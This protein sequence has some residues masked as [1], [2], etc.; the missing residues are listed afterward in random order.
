MGA[1][2]RAHDGSPEPGRRGSVPTGG[3]VTG[4]GPCGGSA[5]A[6]SHGSR[7]VVHREGRRSE[8]GRPQGLRPVQPPPSLV[9]AFSFRRCPPPGLPLLR[10]ALGA[11]GPGAR[12]PRSRHAYVPQSV[13]HRESGTIPPGEGVAARGT[14]LSGPE[15][16]RS[17]RHGRGRGTSGAGLLP[18]RGYPRGAG[19]PPGGRMGCRGRRKVGGRGDPGAPGGHDLPGG[20]PAHGAGRD[21]QGQ[22]G[23]SRGIYGRI[24]P[25]GSVGS[26]SMPSPGSFRGEPSGSWG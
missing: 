10:V 16:G 1:P 5:P 20:A 9:A 15:R 2:G 6:R 26:D 18:R 17:G 14:R 19:S 11:P 4:P 25:S 8:I 22:W 7:D 21:S 13:L 12:R 3:E 24:G 23:R